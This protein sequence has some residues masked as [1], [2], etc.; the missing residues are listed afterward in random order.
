M[1]STPRRLHRRATPSAA[2]R[3]VWLT[4]SH[5]EEENQEEEGDPESEVDEPPPKRQRTEA[6]II[7]IDYAPSDQIT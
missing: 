6:D 5:A 4:I 3:V 1:L 2:Q 7:E